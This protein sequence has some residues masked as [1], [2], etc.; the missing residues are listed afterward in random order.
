M[1]EVESVLDG[2]RDLDRPV[3]IIVPSR[4]LRQHL[5][6]RLVQKRGAIAGLLVQTA[7]SAAREVLQKAKIA[8]PSGDGFFDIVVRRLAGSEEVLASNLEA[9]DDGYG[10]VVGVVRDLLDAGFQP[11]HEEG[12]LD[13]L[14]DLEKPVTPKRLDRARAIVRIAARSH[15]AMSVTENWRSAH[16]FDSAADLLQHKGEEL[17]PSEGVFIHGFADVT[18]V[19]ADFFESLIRVLPTALLIDQ[20]GRPDGGELAQ[21]GVA[22]LGRLVGRFDRPD[23]HQD[24]SQKTPAPEIDLAQGGEL[25]SEMRWVAERARALIGAG[26]VPEEIGIVAR[27]YEGLA[28]PLRR[29]LRRLG[30]PHSGIGER[31]A[32][33]GCRQAVLG[34]AEVLRA[35]PSTPVDLWIESWAGGRMELLLALRKIGVV[36]LE[37]LAALQFEGALRRGVQIPLAV[38]S[39]AT[40]EPSSRRTVTAEILREARRSASSL[41]RVFEEWPDSA[42]ADSH[43]DFTMQV[44]EALGWSTDDPAWREVVPCVTAV[45]GELAVIPDLEP[46]E[47]HRVL[48]D[49]L[50]GL[51]DDPIGGAGGGV[52]LLTV[53]EARAR[54]FDHVFLVG[55][56]RGVFPRVAGDDSLLPDAIRSRL[57]VD[58]LPEMPVRARSADEERYLFAQLLSSAPTIH[59]SWH[60]SALGSV[61]T[62]SPFLAEVLPPRAPDPVAPPLWSTVRADLGPRPPYEHAVL[63]AGNGLRQHLTGALAEA[64]KSGGSAVEDSDADELAAARVD[65]L[66]Q[67]DSSPPN[68][69]PNPW[70]GFVGGMGGTDTRGPAVTTI[71]RIA[72]CPWASFVTRSLRVEPLQDPQLGLPDPRG[73]LVGEVVHRALEEIVRAAVPAT[74]PVDVEDT[75]ARTPRDVGW[76]RAEVFEA[77][78]TQASRDVAAEAGLG[79]LGMGPLLAARSRPYLEVARNTDWENGGRLNGVLA[80]EVSGVAH[81]EGIEQPMRF[82]AD[83]VDR[84]AEGLCLVD[85]KTGK[86]VSEAQKPET[87]RGHLLKEVARGRMLQAAAYASAL[88]DGSARGRYLWLKPDIGDAPEEA[89][90]GVISG[91]EADFIAAAEGAIAAVSRVQEAG[92]MFPRVEEVGSDNIPGHCK[93]C[94]VAEACRRDDSG[95]RHRLVA[96]MENTDADAES[97]DGVAHAL[98]HLGTSKEVD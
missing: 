26:S 17:L 51:G 75:A 76:P 98:W 97:V 29:H 11:G 41:I 86:P 20:P 22:F 37:D 34:V 68:E 13:K 49:G 7:Y 95:F 31:V 88:P 3:R 27:Q 71:E 21:P 59:L 46:H 8:P 52:Q 74:G 42:G 63:S 93:Y 4:S 16:A 9:L 35:G 1:A 82:R 19:V 25:E 79:P 23:R 91:A 45:A 2:H 55:F 32:G 60:L 36:R 80:A 96:W 14:D 54:T 85:Y 43:A 65:V 12:V 44:L 53:T 69:S 56:N 5:L 70:F 48:A 38:D 24:D 67:V 64:I 50:S 92:A 78:L 39:T 84:D 18:G 10:S 57:A 58:V 6:C 30:V 77:I 81:L 72:E 66:E 61:M 15:E 94:A 87:R 89:R 83:R 40:E 73:R 47:W 28:Y 90:W 62:R 33:G